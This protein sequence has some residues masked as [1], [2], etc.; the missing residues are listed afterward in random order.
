M[1]RRWL[2]LGLA[3]GLSYALALAGIALDPYW[4]DNGV[5]EFIPWAERWGWAALFAPALLLVIGPVL[6][7]V[8]R[9][10]AARREIDDNSA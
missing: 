8:R 7:G 6:Y 2:W 10:L 1:K 5:T 9:L 3:I 4:E